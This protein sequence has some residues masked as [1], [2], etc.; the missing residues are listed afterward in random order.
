MPPGFKMIFTAEHQDMD[1]LLAQSRAF[2]ILFGLKSLFIH[3]RTSSF[4]ICEQNVTRSA[5]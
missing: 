4:E 3:G 1:E 2:I 5:F